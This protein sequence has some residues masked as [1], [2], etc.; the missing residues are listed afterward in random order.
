MLLFFAMLGRAGVGISV[1]FTFM[2]FVHAFM[3]HL[4]LLPGVLPAGSG[5]KNEGGGA[6]SEQG[7]F[8]V[9]WGHASYREQPVVQMTI[10]TPWSS[11]SRFQGDIPGLSHKPMKNL[12]P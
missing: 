12:A 6:E 1:H 4:G 2:C 5:G 7:G 3:Q 9:K 8:H 10:L 11:F